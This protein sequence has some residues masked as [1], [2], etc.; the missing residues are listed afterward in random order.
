MGKCCSKQQNQ[1][2]P[3]QQHKKQNKGIDDRRMF[4]VGIEV[5]NKDFNVQLGYN[6]R[7][8][9]NYFDVPVSNNLHNPTTEEEA[10]IACY[11]LRLVS[12]FTPEEE[13]EVNNIS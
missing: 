10:P 11:S 4:K 6:R 9:K 1:R 7:V 12:V 13:Q 2:H 5:L 8:E 3:A